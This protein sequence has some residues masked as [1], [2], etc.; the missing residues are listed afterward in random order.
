MNNRIINTFVNHCIHIDI[1]VYT[2]VIYS[3]H[4]KNTGIT[5]ILYL[6]KIFWTGSFSLITSPPSLD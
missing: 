5:V 4:D 2:F 6:K 3:L 1:L